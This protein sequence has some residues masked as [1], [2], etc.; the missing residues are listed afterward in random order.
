M[1]NAKIFRTVVLI[2]GVLLL[3]GGCALAVRNTVQHHN[4]ANESSCMSSAHNSVVTVFYHADTS[5]AELADLIASTGAPH[6][7]SYPQKHAFSVLVSTA[8]QSR[9]VAALRAQPVV[10]NVQVSAAQDCIDPN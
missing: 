8:D 2:V 6:H 1:G 3:V 5:G 7:D 10:N 9:I 4:D